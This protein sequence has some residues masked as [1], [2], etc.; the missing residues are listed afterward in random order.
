MQCQEKLPN[1][2]HFFIFFFPFDSYSENYGSETT[3]RPLKDFGNV[4]VQKKSH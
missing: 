3:I 1:Q 2:Q 4:S